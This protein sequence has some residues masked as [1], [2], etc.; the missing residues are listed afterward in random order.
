[1][2]FIEHKIGNLVVRQ[3]KK[4]GYINATKL[5]RAYNHKTGSKKTPR[6]WFETDRSNIYIERISDR[7]GLKVSELVERRNQEFWIHPKLAICFARWLS[8]DFEIMVDEWVE[9]WMLNGKEPTAPSNNELHPYQR[10]WYERWGLFEQYTKLPPGYWCIFEHIAKLMRD[11]E[12]KK[13][14]LYDKATI[15]ISVGKTWCHWL[16]TQGYD[17]NFEKYTHHYPDDRGEQLANIYPFELLGKF[18]SWLQ[19]TYV[20]DKFPSYVR[21]F[22]TP[23]ECKL[24]SEAIG[25]EVKPKKKRLKPSKDKS[26]KQNNSGDKVKGNQ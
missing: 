21:E 24:I 25:Y 19:E 5:T 26:G 7:T 23:E 12:A 10:V 11:L 20:P 6:Q 4:D 15:D 2:Q 13:V 9:T 3:R 1:M 14:Y 18:H 16:R 17:T 22:C 8:V